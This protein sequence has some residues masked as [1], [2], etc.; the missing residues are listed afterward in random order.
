[1]EIHSL[2]QPGYHDVA[3][4]Q[5]AFTF[6]LVRLLQPSP[7]VNGLPKETY[8]DFPFT[9][10]PNNT[11][12]HLVT[13]G[14]FQLPYMSHITGHSHSTPTA[15]R[16]AYEGNLILVEMTTKIRMKIKLKINMKQCCAQ[17]RYKNYCDHIKLLHVYTE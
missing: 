12:M 7:Q 6:G 11:E 16:N 17:G 3:Q 1:M 9:H 13:D 5:P 14:E 2:L 15:R 10:S 8:N 4:F